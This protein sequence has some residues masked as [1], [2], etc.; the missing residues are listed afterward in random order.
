MSVYC[1]QHDHT[2]SLKLFNGQWF[3][4]YFIV[5]L[6]FERKRVSLFPV[7]CFRQTVTALNRVF[8]FFFLFFS[9]CTVYRLLI[10]CRAALFFTSVFW[11][12]HDLVSHGE[13]ISLIDAAW[14]RF[15]IQSKYKAVK[16]LKS[17]STNFCL[18]EKALLSLILL[19]QTLAL[20]SRYVMSAYPGSKPYSFHSSAVKTYLW[21]GWSDTNMLI[22]PTLLFYW[23]N[24]GS[25][26][27]ENHIQEPGSAI[28]NRMSRI[29][30]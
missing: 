22:N 26:I 24:V 9:S 3:T 15:R 5:A 21:A 17:N 29:I 18:K 10:P 20:E 28:G 1:R 7:C 13:K 30:V 6:W 16:G 2:Y 25:F 23:F 4:R 11:D 14:K 19:F 8:F 27:P 12:H